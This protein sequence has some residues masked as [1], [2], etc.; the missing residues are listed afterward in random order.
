M[1]FDVEMLESNE[2]VELNAPPSAAANHPSPPITQPS[3]NP[4]SSA[5][6]GTS[7]TSSNGSDIDDASS[8]DHLIHD[9]N[10]LLP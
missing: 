5:T 4:A 7:S 8:I 3:V 10:D 2:D 9:D 1:D 6:T